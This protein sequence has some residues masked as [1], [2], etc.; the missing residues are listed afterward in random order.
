MK[1]FPNLITSLAG[2]CLTTLGLLLTQQA[3]AGGKDLASP[4]M[5]AINQG[6]ASQ[7]QIILQRNIFDPNRGRAEPNRERQPHIET[8]S[9]RGAA[10]KLGK[11]FDAFFTG[12]GAPASGTVAVNDEINGFKVQGIKLSEVKL[13]ATNHEVVVLQD[14]TGMTRHDG[15][16]WIKVFVPAFYG[17]S[18]QTRT[19]A[20][21][22][23]GPYSSSLTAATDDNAGANGGGPSR[24]SGSYDTG[25][26]VPT[27]QADIPVPPAPINPALLA[28]MQARR[29]QEN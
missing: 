3:A 25:G 23:N 10:E 4:A 2:G 1:T 26:G 13:M 27:T 6:G 22:D 18:A 15:G 24:N 14:Q 7:F 11:G 29:A 20:G 8:F 28:R 16:P 5:E 21:N 19:S 9:F 17:S 12:D